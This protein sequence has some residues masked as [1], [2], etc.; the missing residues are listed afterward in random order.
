MMA[1]V[2]KADN[3]QDRVAYGGPGVLQ[4]NSNSDRDRCMFN[5]AP[6][7]KEDWLQGKL[8]TEEFSEAIQL[9]NQ[10][11]CLALVGQTHGV[12]SP[13]DWPV[14]Q[15]L[16]YDG[17]TTAI[18]QL[19]AKYNGRGVKF[20]LEQGRAEIKYHGESMSNSKTQYTTLH[21]IF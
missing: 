8:T 3:N 4:L 18:E 15:K 13:N 7:L 10:L 12:F 19:N 16:V 20:N 5:P 17:T 9:I 2:E 1:A 11:S 21:I 6:P 14:R